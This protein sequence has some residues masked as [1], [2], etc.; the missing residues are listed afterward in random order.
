MIEGFGSKTWHTKWLF[1]NY[2][3]NNIYID[4]TIGGFLCTIILACVF[5]IKLR[6]T[7]KRLQY[8]MSDVR[9]VANIGSVVEIP[10]SERTSYKS[11]IRNLEEEPLQ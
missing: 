3:T 6:R 1:C 5:Y 9:N 4:A 2:Y 10:M 8:E 11:L 7:R